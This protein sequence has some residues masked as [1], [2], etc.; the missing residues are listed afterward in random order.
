MYNSTGN[1]FSSSI[2]KPF[3]SVKK[4]FFS[5]STLIFSIG[6]PSI[7]SKILRLI[8]CENMKDGI[9]KKSKFNMIFFINKIYKGLSQ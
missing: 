5:D 3:L 8:D 4:V 7:L 9:V 2:I 1:N 6:V